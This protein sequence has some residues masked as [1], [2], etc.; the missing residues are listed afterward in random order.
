MLGSSVKHVFKVI[1][2]WRIQ[3]ESDEIQNSKNT[4]ILDGLRICLVEQVD[5]RCRWCIQSRK[6]VKQ[7]VRAWVPDC[8]SQRAKKFL[9]SRIL[10]HRKAKLYS[11]ANNVEFLHKA[12][13]VEEKET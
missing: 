1:L 4:S 13:L 7:M 3:Q 8:K 9:G 5:M 6:A 2:G 11:H 12:R 10:L